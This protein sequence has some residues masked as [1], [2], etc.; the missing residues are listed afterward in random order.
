MVW[1]QASDD[2]LASVGRKPTPTSE[3]DSLPPRAAFL[4]SQEESHAHIEEEERAPPRLSGPAE[5]PCTDTQHS[6]F[7]CI[8]LG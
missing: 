4:A 1:G 5:H 7:L 6:V 8:R 2:S 3:S